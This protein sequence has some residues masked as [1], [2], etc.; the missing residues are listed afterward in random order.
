MNLY[1]YVV[2]LLDGV[3]LDKFDFLVPL[4]MCIIIVLSLGVTFRALLTIF[5]KFFS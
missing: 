1:S 2:S 3:D 4:I 5:N